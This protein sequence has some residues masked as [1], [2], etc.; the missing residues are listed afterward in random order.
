MMS[1]Q[2]NQRK[3][4]ATPLKPPH[5]TG[6]DKLDRC[7]LSSISTTKGGAVETGLIKRQEG[8]RKTFSLARPD[9]FPH[10]CTVPEI[11]FSEQS[12]SHRALSNMHPHHLFQIYSA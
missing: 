1:M 11:R 2:M 9:S 3:R 4:R 10:I 7:P 8:F 6:S 12:R 5:L